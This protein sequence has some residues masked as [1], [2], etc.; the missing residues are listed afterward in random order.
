[1]LVRGFTGHQTGMSDE[2]YRIM[3]MNGMSPSGLP[4]PEPPGESELI[5]ERDHY[6][7]ALCRLCGAKAEHREEP[8]Q[9]RHGHT[10]FYVR[11]M[12]CLIRTINKYNRGDAAVA[13][14]A[15]RDKDGKRPPVSSAEVDAI[16]GRP[17]VSH[18]T[19]EARAVG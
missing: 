15:R 14:P 3:R 7:L 6:K 8:E 19:A 12:V 16:S 2:Q 11:C 4:L 13:R 18:R 17:P 1:M 9:D 5:M 10:L